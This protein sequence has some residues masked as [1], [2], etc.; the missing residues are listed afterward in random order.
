MSVTVHTTV[1]DF[2]MELFCE[3][4]PKV[5]GW[6]VLA[7]PTGNPCQI[8]DKSRLG[9]LPKYQGYII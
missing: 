5:G 4:C 1:G 2:K 9:W 8:W 3:Q 7:P 6:N